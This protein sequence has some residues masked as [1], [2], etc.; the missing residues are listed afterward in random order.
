MHVNTFL[1]LYLCFA[2]IFLFFLNLPVCFLK[3]RGKEAVELEVWR[4]GKNLVEDVG[5]ETVRIYCMEKYLFQLIKKKVEG[6]DSYF[7]LMLRD[8]SNI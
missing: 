3:E 5:R 8:P 1:M 2:F 4:S 7:F 6:E